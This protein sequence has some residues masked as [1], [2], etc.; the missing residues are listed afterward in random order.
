M[1]DIM[2]YKGK[3]GKEQTNPQKN[4][5]RPIYMK[6]IKKKKAPKLKQL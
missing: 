6:N 3:K 4:Y 1:T 2:N 5:Q